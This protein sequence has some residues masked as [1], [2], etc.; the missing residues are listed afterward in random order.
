MLRLREK[1][2]TYAGH[3]HE[4]CLV[5]LISYQYVLLYNAKHLSLTFPSLLGQLSLASRYF[6]ITVLTNL[7][8]AAEDFTAVSFFRLKRHTDHT[9]A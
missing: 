9:Y 7:S 1:R 5:C 4:Q 8:H 3:F 2:V 6:S